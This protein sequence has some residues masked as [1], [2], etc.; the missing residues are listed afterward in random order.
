MRLRGNP[1]RCCLFEA[2]SFPKNR[3][4]LFGATLAGTN[5]S[6]VCGLYKK[7]MDLFGVNFQLTR[8]C[9]ADQALRFRNHMAG[10][11]ETLRS[12]LA[13]IAAPIVRNCGSGAA[14]ACNPAVTLAFA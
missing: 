6:D 5:K 10:C 9:G 14:A 11:A 4:T 8:G 3:F 12:P 7:P 13:P 2:C 1:Q